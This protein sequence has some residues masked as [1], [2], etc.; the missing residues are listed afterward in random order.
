MGKTSNRLMNFI[1]WAIG[2]LMLTSALMRYR[3][4]LNLLNTHP[5][6]QQ[7]IILVYFISAI[8]GFIGL[9]LLRVWGF[10][11]AYIN[12]LT[13]TVFLSMSVLPFWLRY[14]SLGQWT[15]K[16]VVVVNLLILI[17]I[18]FLHG[19]KGPVK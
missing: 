6:R 12:I 4:F 8:I 7:A 15:S 13:A 17:L 19:R 11:A 16:I 18:A 1:L 10:I 3:M 14:I 2:A 5:F 9:L